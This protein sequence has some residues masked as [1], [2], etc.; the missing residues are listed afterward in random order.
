MREDTFMPTQYEIFAGL[1][2]DKRN[3]TVIFTS[4]QGLHPIAAHAL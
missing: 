2:V 4:H 1:D 3:I